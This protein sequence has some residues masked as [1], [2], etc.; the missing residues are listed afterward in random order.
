LAAVLSPGFVSVEDLGKA[1]IIAAPR[2]LADQF[3]NTS[4]ASEARIVVV[5]VVPLVCTH[6]SI[7]TE[8][9]NLSSIFLTRK[10]C[11]VIVN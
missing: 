10:T 9:S 5:E 6:I 2:V 8:L 3:L 1:A 11:R 4:L 7:I